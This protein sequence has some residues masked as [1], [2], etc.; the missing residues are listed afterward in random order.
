M[1]FDEIIGYIK[2]TNLLVAN[3][4]MILAIIL[5]LLLAVLI[6]IIYRINY[7]GDDFQIKFARSLILVA[8]AAAMVIMT[9]KIDIVLS[10]GL[11][12]SLSIIRYRTTVKDASDMVYVFW[13]LAVGIG[14]GAGAYLAVLAGSFILVITSFLLSRIKTVRETVLL[15]IEANTDNKQ[16]FEEV[17]KFI[18]KKYKRCNT[19][20]CDI[21]LDVQ[22]CIMELSVNPDLMNEI[23]HEIDEIEG[24]KMVKLYRQGHRL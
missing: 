10:L 8:L 23:S 2:T 21:S 17:R 4:E 7:R 14:C 15:E 20:M 11:V 12:G 16:I 3:K 18:I 24:I 6:S 22:K 13:S 5:T 9:I 19:K 1:T